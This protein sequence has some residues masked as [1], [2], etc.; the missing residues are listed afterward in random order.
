MEYKE[1]VL[2]GNLS[3]YDSHMYKAN[4]YEDEI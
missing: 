3:I 4:I 1:V 2:Q